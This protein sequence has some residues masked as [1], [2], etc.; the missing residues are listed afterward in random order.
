MSDAQHAK[1]LRMTT[2]PVDR[3]IRQLAAPTVV[4]MLITAL[5]NIVDTFFVG[6]LG[7]SATGAI[8]V[9]YSLMAIIQ[10]VGFCFGH[11][12]G[13]YI[14]RK[15]G[16]ENVTD[17]A[18]MAMVGF[19][20]SFLLGFL[21]TIV[22]LLFLPSLAMALGSTETIR[23]YAEQYMF[24]VLIGAPFF[25]SSLTLNNQLRLQGN[26]R[27]AMVGIVTGA[28]VNCVLDPVLIFGFHLGVAG[29]GLSTFLSQL[30]SF[31]IL[32]YYTQHSDAVSL[33]LR[34]FLPT[35][36]RY[37]AI[38]QGGA[39]SLCRQGTHSISNI[40]INHAMKIFGDELFA[41]MTIVIRLSNFIFAGTAGIGQGFQPVCGFN[42]GAKRYD[43]VRA[44]YF[45]TQKLAFV[46]LLALTIALAIFTRPVISWFSDIPTVIDWGV[47][48]QR[49]QCLSIPF[50]GF[51]MM[52]SMLLQNIN[53]YKQ[54]TLLALCRSG[55]FL[56]PAILVLP[57]FWGAYGVMI[58]QPVAD[59]CSFA[60][61]AVMHHRILKKLPS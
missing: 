44:S 54:A 35:R 12:S 6:Q 49:L 26:A 24:F 11:G 41:A 1:F 42:Y 56:I 3:L 52:T 9:T 43:R 7:A 16:E 57:R 31:V 38:L 47:L 28:V 14:S 30:T 25:A 15:L 59:A 40:V 46:F 33:R 37:M 5:Y 8:G 45:Y 23:P 51:V 17:A 29:A 20:S 32:F 55:L 36:E 48:A 4:S 61:A 10:A 53:S 34:S 19:A 58:A 21:M 2:E 22:G 60:V 50:I 27:L 18:I 13:N 39:P